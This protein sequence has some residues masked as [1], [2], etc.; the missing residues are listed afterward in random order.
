MHYYP[1]IKES[2]LRCT[3][4]EFH[5]HSK[6]QWW[7]KKLNL[8]YTN[9]RLVFSPVL[10]P[11]VISYF[12]YFF[13]LFETANVLRNENTSEYH[14]VLGWLPLC[15]LNQD[16]QQYYFHIFRTDLSYSIFHYGSWVFYYSKLAL[17]PDNF[18]IS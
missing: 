12:L 13:W 7:S 5:Y 2:E 14:S 10:P 16:T 15:V 6:T 4:I 3:Q 18:F 9:L 1:S 11:Q 8:C 17:C